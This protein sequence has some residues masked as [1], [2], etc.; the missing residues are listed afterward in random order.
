M[1]EQVWFPEE[2]KMPNNSQ[3]NGHT[4]CY[5]NAS[6]H[7]VWEVMAMRIQVQ[8]RAQSQKQIIREDALLNSTKH[9]DEKFILNFSVKFV[10]LYK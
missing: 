1:T 6:R 7:Q 4:P 9:P 10:T 3:N 5:I 2:L 8:T